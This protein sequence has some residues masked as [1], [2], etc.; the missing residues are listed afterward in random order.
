MPG[1]HVARDP[2]RRPGHV[3]LPSTVREVFV[4]SIFRQFFLFL[5]FF[6]CFLRKINSKIFYESNNFSSEILVGR[7]F[8]KKQIG[9]IKKIYEKN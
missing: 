2:A 6:C 9:E 8:F 4:P 3:S 1:L 7:K 5:K